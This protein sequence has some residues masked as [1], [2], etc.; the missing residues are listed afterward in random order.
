MTPIDRFRLDVRREMNSGVDGV[1]AVLFYLRRRGA[2][3]LPPGI[4]SALSFADS[5]SAVAAVAESVDNSRAHAAWL[6]DLSL[7]HVARRANP[8]SQ[9][10]CRVQ[11]IHGVYAPGFHFTAWGHE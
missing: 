8:P 1:D 3:T 2:M 10:T 11:P 7:C 6:A 4:C 5:T 9:E